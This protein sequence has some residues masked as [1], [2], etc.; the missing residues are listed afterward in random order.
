MNVFRECSNPDCRFRYPEI[1]TTH[2]KAYCPKCGFE[3][4]IVEEIPPNKGIFTQEHHNKGLRS[5]FRVILDNIRSIYNVGSI[6]RTS[7]G[8]G[9]K[10]LLLC[11]I[12][13]T[14]H[15][16][17][18]SKTSL[19]AESSVE[20]TYHPNAVLACKSLQEQGYQL[21]SLE[22]DQDTT[23]LYAVPQIFINQPVALVIG[24]EVTGIDPEILRISDLIISIPMNGLKSSYNVATAYGIAVSYFYALSIS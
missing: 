11:G 6:F 17:R 22:I 16:P 12:T 1:G 4:R 8:F 7:D 23:N 2:S 13:S 10:E 5:D 21:A 18:F 24:N 14:P 3:A 15:N 9:V 20:W 19:G